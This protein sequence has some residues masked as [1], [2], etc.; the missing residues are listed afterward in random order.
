MAF[1]AVIKM[2]KWKSM[3]WAAHIA[4]IEGEE[5]RVCGN[6]GEARRNST[7][8]ISVLKWESNIKMELGG[9]VVCALG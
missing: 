3:R 5:E 1:F 9:I 4:G 6:D 8:L 7:L 2:F